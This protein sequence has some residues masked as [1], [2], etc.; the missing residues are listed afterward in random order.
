MS[1]WAKLS[2]SLSQEVPVLHADILKIL[3][4][5][6]LIVLFSLRFIV[7]FAIFLSGI[8]QPMILPP[9][10][11]LPPLCALAL[12][13][14]AC[15]TY[16][17]KSSKGE[18]ITAAP[19]DGLSARQKNTPTKPLTLKALAAKATNEDLR[20]LLLDR[21]EEIEDE[22]D[23]P[24][25]EALLM[26]DFIDELKRIHNAYSGADAANIGDLCNLIVQTL[27]AQ[28]CELLDSDKWSPE[29]QRA[30]KIDYCLPEGQ[31]PRISSKHATGLKWRGKILRKQEVQIQKSKI[32]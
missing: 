28:E 30:I 26:V 25:K 29:I 15:I 12:I 7:R 17:T 4:I 16:R 11:V 8:I 6:G 10:F 19:K 3:H 22:R 31:E 27:S 13:S 9:Q 1:I 5:L 21:V 18:Q 2:Y 24:Q 14:I 20:A 32:S 23:N